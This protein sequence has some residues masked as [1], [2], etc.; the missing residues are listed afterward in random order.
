MVAC[1]LQASGA[2]SRWP[3]DRKYHIGHYFIGT[4]PAHLE[5]LMLHNVGRDIRSPTYELTI[6]PRRAAQPPG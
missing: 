2:Q 4:R 6:A 5:D 3:A 1:R